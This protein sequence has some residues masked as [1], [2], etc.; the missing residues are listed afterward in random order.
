MNLKI[1]R[2]R[3]NKTQEEMA[4]T[5]GVAGSTYWRWEV[6]RRTPPAVAE[7]MFLVAQ[8]LF[9]RGLLEVCTRDV[10]NETT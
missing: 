1:L 3:M 2:T 8:W 6:G 4:S 5:F 7:R 10:K 9:D